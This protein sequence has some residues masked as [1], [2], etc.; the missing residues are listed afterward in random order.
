KLAHCYVELGNAEEALRYAQKSADVFATAH[1][2]RRL[3]YASFELGRAQVLN[4]EVE[5]GL[6]TLERVLD[7]ATESEPRDFEF[8]V[9]IEK[10]I[11]EI[12]HTMGRSEEAV[13]IERRI[14]S[15]AEILED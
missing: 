15:V 12:L 9:A 2:Q 13:E 4:G 8:I 10:R 7:V 1:D 11:A 3:T 14:A 5:E 6:S